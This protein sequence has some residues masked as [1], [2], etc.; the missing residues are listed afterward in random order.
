MKY[1]LYRIRILNDIIYLLSIKNNYDL[2]EEKHNWSTRQRVLA[3]IKVINI[4]N[5]K[6]RQ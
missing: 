5:F 4:T 2:P 6:S 3:L 1:L